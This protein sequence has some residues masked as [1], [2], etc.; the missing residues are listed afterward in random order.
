VLEE[1]KSSLGALA[2]RDGKP[3]LALL[4]A[5]DD[6]SSLRRATA[7][8]LLCQAGPANINEKIRALLQDPMP[9]VRLRAAL[10]LAQVQEA[11]AVD[12]SIPLIGDPPVAQGHRA[13]D[14]FTTPPA[15]QGPK[16]Q[17]KDDASRTAVRDAWQAWWNA[18]DGAKLI[19]EFN[20]RTVTD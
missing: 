17:L 4:K 8:E 18:R 6:E 1:V 2:F 10:A 11:K 9:N 5:L 15:D 12:T 13:E 3:E 20:H 14:F 16:V 19:D 7:V